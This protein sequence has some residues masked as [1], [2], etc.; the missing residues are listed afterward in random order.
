M[1][2]AIAIRPKGIASTLFNF[3]TAIYVTSIS[4]LFWSLL[5]DIFSIFTF[6]KHYSNSTERKYSG[7]VVKA[8]E[9]TYRTNFITGWQFDLEAL[10]FLTSEKTLLF[11]F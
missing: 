6:K 11:V 8:A 3:C 5:F 4:V 7:A 10:E 1:E 2:K 9:N